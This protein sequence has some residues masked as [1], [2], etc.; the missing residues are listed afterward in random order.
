M[1]QYLRDQTLKNL[2]M[3]EKA[4]EEINKA[5]VQIRDEENK[6]IGNDIKRPKRLLLTYTIR[7][8]GKGFKLYGYG[9]VMDYFRSAKEVERFIFQLDSMEHFKSYKYTGKGVEIRVDSKNP[10][11]CFL[12]VQD[13][14]QN[15]VENTFLTLQETINKHDNKN[16][17]MRNRFVVSSIQIFGV[18]AGVLLSLWLASKVSPKLNTPYPYGIAFIIALLIF[19]NIWT[20]LYVIILRC[21][22][23]FWPN[24]SFK[25]VKGVR[26]FARNA[27]FAL[28]VA[29]CIAIVTGIGCRLYGF[30]LSLVK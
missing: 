8:D 27:T 3:S 9:K 4:L 14:Q 5:L 1:S 2:N 11:N 23:I 30:I 15:W 7:F 6:Q 17:L 28:F 18:L 20:Y 13:D 24:I 29:G 22:D 25:E 10:N 26:K 16:N 12:I 19:S 21:V